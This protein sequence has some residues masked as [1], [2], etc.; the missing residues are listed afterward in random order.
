MRTD[1]LE[2]RG[3][4]ERRGRAVHVIQGVGLDGQR[5]GDF[6]RRSTGRQEP[7][8]GLAGRTRNGLQNARRKPLGIVNGHPVEARLA[9]TRDLLEGLG[10]GPRALEGPV[11]FLCRAAEPRPA[12]LQPRHRRARGGRARLEPGRF[13]QR[14]QMQT[15][16]GHARAQELTA[17]D[18]RGVGARRAGRW[19]AAWDREMEVGVDQA[20]QQRVAGAVDSP[21]LLVSPGARGF[22]D[23]HATVAEQHVA[24]R[25]EAVAGPD[26]GVANEETRGVAGLADDGARDPQAGQQ[27]G[28][29]DPS[30]PHH[31]RP[32]LR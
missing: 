22:E 16:G 1:R 13:L 32:A 14:R 5:G 20:W 12:H 11:V 17:G 26:G 4:I 6:L 7:E 19:K 10:A 30:T 25:D 23:R 24:V 29:D 28:P 31:A 21:D 9:S 8:P 18:V 27:D 3:R 2:Y 15:A